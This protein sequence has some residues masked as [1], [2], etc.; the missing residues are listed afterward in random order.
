MKLAK[1]LFLGS[2]AGLA[3]VWGHRLPTCRSPKAAA[4]EYVRVCSTYGAGF[5]YIPGTETCLRIGGRVRAE[6]SYLEPL[7]RADNRSASALV[8]ASSSTPA[9]LPPM[10]CCAPSSVSRSPA[11]PAS[12]TS[13]A[14]GQHL[15]GCRSGLHPVRRPDRRSRDVVLHQQ[16]YRERELGTL[17]FYGLPR[18]E[19]VG[20]HLLLRQRLLGHARRWKRARCATSTRTARPCARCRSALPGP[21]RQLELHRHLGF[22]SALGRPAPDPQHTF[23]AVT[24]CGIF[25]TP[26][27]AWPFRAGST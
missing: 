13:N 20:L 12:I 21:R 9:P 6:Y 18:R 27:S 15:A 19:P 4:V 11:T 1:S 3:A 26:N 16:R 24:G 17:R 25:R 10:A 14:A 5:F 8:A 23:V 2:V 22:G 7:T